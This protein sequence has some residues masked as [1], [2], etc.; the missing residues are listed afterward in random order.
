MEAHTALT[1]FLINGKTHFVYQKLDREKV[2]ILLINDDLSC[3][4]GVAAVATIK[5]EGFRKGAYIEILKNA[6]KVQDSSGES[7]SYEIKEG[8]RDTLKFSVL[9]KVQ[10]GHIFVK[11]AEFILKLVT[12]KSAAITEF[13]RKLAI[14]SG[15]ASAAMSEVKTLKH[16]R[17]R[18]RALTDE[19]AQQ[20][21][22]SEESM[23]TGMVWVL[24]EKNRC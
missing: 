4:R 11:G 3:Y 2:E 6:L 10:D 16:D 19:A 14:L 8:K 20:R 7:F 5:P 22:K 17:E 21:L 18:F 23:L 12:D 9:F 13:L 1:E 24:N 15:G